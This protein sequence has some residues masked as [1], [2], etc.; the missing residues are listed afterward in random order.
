MIS[1]FY[2]FEAARSALTASQAG[3]NLTGQ[4]IANVNTEDY[5]RQVA[6]LT[7][8]NYTSGAGRF[9][10]SKVNI[11]QGVTVTGIS[12][13]RDAFLDAEVRGANSSYNTWEVSLSALTDIEDVLDETTND[14]LYAMLGD[15][16][17]QL[18]ELSNNAG[19]PEYESIVRSSGEKLTR[20]I[21]QYASQLGKIRGQLSSNLSISVDSVNTVVSKINHVNDLIKDQSLRGSVSNE[22]LDM[23]NGYLDTLS[24]YMDI[25]VSVNTDATVSVTASDGSDIL[26]SSYSVATASGV[27]SLIRT[28]PG[29]NNY[30]FQPAQGSLTG[31]LQVLN[32]AGVYASA[33][34]FKGLT[35]YESALDDFA[36][37]FADAFNQ[38]NHDAGGDDLFADLSGGAVTAAGITISDQWRA[39]PGCIICGTD[40]A[41]DNIILMLGAV[42]AERAVSPY[43]TGSFDEY[44]NALMSDIAVDVN[45]YI[46]MKT[47]Y[48]GILTAASEQRESVTGVSVNEETVNMMKYQKSYQAAARLMTALDE[49]LDVLINRTGIVGR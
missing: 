40:S 25:S 14:G 24:G 34:A 18:E 9:A 20:V 45:Y 15:F 29:G 48:G 27:T 2:G 30:D 31:Y 17:Q 32:G 38:I 6:D 3:L 44:V 42:D 43:F 36:A 22:L 47:M 21:N 8:A 19:S 4:N 16:Y 10:G 41:N 13:I 26:S 39:D 7:A 5:T 12:Q 33:D 46:D 35:Y 49:A 1:S 28:D 11:G 23:R 37:S